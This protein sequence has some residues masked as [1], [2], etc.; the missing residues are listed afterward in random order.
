MA[1]GL[2]ASGEQAAA[3]G[4]AVVGGL[5]A[6]TVATLFVV[7]AMYAVLA[8]GAPHDRSL[9]TDEAPRRPRVRQSWQ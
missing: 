9:L 4:R 1:L 6:A 5:A 7:P 3:L 2:G 8:A